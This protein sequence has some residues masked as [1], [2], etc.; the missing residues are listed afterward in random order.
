MLIAWLKLRQRNLGPILDAN[1]WAVNTKAKVNIPFGGVA[2]RGG[3]LPPGAQRDLRDP[4]APARWPVLVLLVLALWKVL[5]QIEVLAG[6]IWGKKP[7]ADQYT[8]T[9]AYLVP[10]LF[11]AAIFFL[12]K[13][14]KAYRLPK[15]LTGFFAFLLLAL[16]LWNFGV[17]ERI[18]PGKLPK[19]PWQKHRETRDPTAYLE[20]GKPTV[21]LAE[22]Q[23]WRAFGRVRNKTTDTR[24]D[25]VVVTVTLYFEGEV[26][27]VCDCIV[28]F[29][30]EPGKEAAYTG[31]FTSEAEPKYDQLEAQVTKFEVS[32]R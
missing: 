20:P 3:R 30:D 9:V 32:S 4:Y 26:V 23:T 27:T 12:W 15:L 16:C 17:I 14:G 5:F 10:F 24:I 22:G 11:L 29:A 13:V 1:G 2:H 6:V 31:Q 7:L 19:T 8:S 18:V 21:K 28:G 25:K